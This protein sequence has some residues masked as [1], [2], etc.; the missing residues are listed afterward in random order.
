MTFSAMNTMPSVRATTANPATAQPSHS[1]SPSHIAARKGSTS[2]MPFVRTRAT[3]A[4]TL[5]PGEPAATTS[6]KA[7]TKRFESVTASVASLSR[8]RQIDIARRI[9][10]VKHALR[11]FHIVG[12]FGEENIGHESLGIAVVQREPTRLHL[13]HDPVTGQEYMVGMRQ[14]Q[15]VADDLACRNRRWIGRVIAVAA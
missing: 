15:R 10:F 12:R 11:G 4:A 7:N 13:H 3:S 14:L 1:A 5:G 2:R 6:A 9:G 8:H